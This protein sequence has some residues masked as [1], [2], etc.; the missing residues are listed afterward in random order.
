MKFTDSIIRWPAVCLLL[1]FASLFPAHG[2]AYGQAQQSR[3]IGEVISA[4]AGKGFDVR[5]DAGLVTHIRV[6]ER[7]RV[8]RIPAGESSLAKG[9]QIKADDIAIGDRLLAAGSTSD[10]SMLTA[11]QLV[12][13][14][15]GEIQK[16]RQ[17][18]TEE[19]RTRGIA[20]VVTAINP[21]TKE[22]TLLPRGRQDATPIVIAASDA[23]RFRRYAPNSVKFSDAKASSLAEI[24]RGD[25]LRALGERSSDGSR[26]RP[27]E[28]V[29]GSFLTVIGVVSAISPSTSEIKLNVQ[30]VP[31]P[32]MLRVTQDATLRRITPKLAASLVRESA[33]TKAVKNEKV[34]PGSEVLERLAPM[35]FSDLKQ[36]DVLAFTSGATRDLSHLTAVT[37]VGGIDVLIASL[38]KQGGLP[39]G[40]ALNSGLP[41]GML[42]TIMGQ[43]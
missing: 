20:G 37:V 40:P 7:T 6:D 38:Q 30:G 29:S 5:S 8:L 4:D 43:P 22:I 31:Q 13:M 42:D 12:V 23:T 41:S 21:Q 15:R 33:E 25:H 35:V 18:E 9:E 2:P 26:F 24:R 36:G 32:I 34:S 3:V 10:Q 16:M 1:I 28:I 14:S 11:T 17:H 39:A 27:Q 19:W